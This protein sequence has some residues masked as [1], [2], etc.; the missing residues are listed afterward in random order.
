MGRE[1]SVA[2][3][4]TYDACETLELLWVATKARRAGTQFVPRVR[5]DRN[6][7]CQAPRPAL[8]LWLAGNPD[9]FGAVLCR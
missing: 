1:L 8:A 2:S 5:I 3:E 9:P 6:P 4:S 7:A